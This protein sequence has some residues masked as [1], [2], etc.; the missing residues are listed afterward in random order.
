MHG[1]GQAEPGTSLWRGS[2]SSKPGLIPQSRTGAFLG[3]RVRDGEAARGAGQARLRALRT[4]N[5]SPRPYRRLRKEPAL[6]PW[7]GGCP[8]PPS[9]AG[10]GLVLSPLPRH[11]AWGQTVTLQDGRRRRRHPQD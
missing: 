6:Q 10:T 8:A 5:S 9:V 4:R 2:S 3:R 7:H 1:A 11:T